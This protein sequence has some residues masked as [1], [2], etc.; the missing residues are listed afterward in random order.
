[1]NLRKHFMKPKKNA[2]SL[3]VFIEAVNYGEIV[4]LVT[5]GMKVVKLDFQSV[6]SKTKMELGKEMNI[7]E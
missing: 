2:M 4:K 7:N 5:V 6:Y 3:P 1:M